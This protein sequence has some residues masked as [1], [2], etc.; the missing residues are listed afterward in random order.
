MKNQAL[1]LLLIGLAVGI[2]G[3][4][5]AMRRMETTATNKSVAINVAPANSDGMPGMGMSGP[6]SAPSES[7][8]SMA[9]MTSNLS[10][11][12][13]DAFDKE[14]I[15]E[16]ILHHQGAI[17]M[18]KLAATQASHREVRDL[19]RNIIDAQTGEIGQMQD[20]Q[21]SWGY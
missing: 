6:T 3:T 8:M 1:S 5:F 21:K 7:S 17:G 9:Q 19:A 12:S 18:A 20:W 4:A 15:S 14:F 10:G 11:L 13:G 2:G 16:M